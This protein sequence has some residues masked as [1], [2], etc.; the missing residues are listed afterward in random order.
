MIQWT[1]RGRRIQYLVISIILWGLDWMGLINDS[2]ESNINQRFN[3]LLSQFF[4]GV[5]FGLIYRSIQ[6]EKI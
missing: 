6:E 1:N 4:I 3:E 5:C 2:N